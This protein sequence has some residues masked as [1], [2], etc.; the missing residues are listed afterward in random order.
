MNLKMYGRLQFAYLMQFAIWGSWNIA[1][2]ALSAAKGFNP[3]VLYAWFAFGALFAP[4]IGPLADSKFAAQKVLSFMHFLGGAALIACGNISNAETVDMNLFKWLMFAAGL[5]YMPSIPLINA[6]VFKHIPNKDKASLVFIFGTIG[7]ILINFLVKPT[8]CFYWGGAVSIA[9]GV[10]ALTLPNTPPSGAKNKDPFGLKALALFKRWDFAAFMICA[11]MVSIFGSNFYFPMFGGYVND[12]LG[13]SP[14]LAAKFGTLNQ[15]SELLFM[16]A[17]AFAVGKFG[18][19]WVLAFGLAAWTVRYGLFA[20]GGMSLAVIAILLH[21]LAYAFLYTASYMFGDKVAPPELKASVQ[22]LI[23]FLLL[24]VGQIVSGYALDYLK[25]DNPMHEQSEIAAAAKDVVKSADFAVVVASLDKNV[26]GVQ[27]EDEKALEALKTSV[28]A[29]KEE[30]AQKKVEERKTKYFEAFDAVAALEDGKRDGKAR[31]ALI[32]AISN[33]KFVVNPINEA[34]SSVKGYYDGQLIAGV[35]EAADAAAAG[36]VATEKYE[37]V[38]DINAQ[39]KVTSGVLAEL[40]AVAGKTAAVKWDKLL[41]IPTVFCLIWTVLFVVLG[42]E[43]K[44][45]EEEAAASEAA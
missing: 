18:L 38:K 26:A 22:S 3:G 44:A 28:K 29:V 31:A 35:S 27:M 6:V 41:Y 39:A 43:P 37:V 5:A 40:D 4:V 34:A 11:F 42:K 45:A 16:T 33:L 17:L 12:I 8:T 19:K 14:E 2:G 10:Y 1:L 9:F 7:W 23:A 24:G 21:G 25:A 20:M 13:V 15:V 32:E 30:D 36:T